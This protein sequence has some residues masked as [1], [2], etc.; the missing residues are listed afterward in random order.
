[1][2]RILC[3]IWPSLDIITD[4]RGVVLSINIWQGCLYTSSV[5]IAMAP[6]FNVSKKLYYYPIAIN[7]YSAIVYFAPIFG[8]NVKFLELNSWLAAIISIAITYPIML[9][10]KHM[11]YLSLEEKATGDFQDDLI[12]KI[13]KLDQENKKLKQQISSVLNHEEKF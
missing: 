8:Y 4:S 5:F 9:M 11:R 12:D 10:L 6:F 3:W 13:K 2:D 7:A 1:M